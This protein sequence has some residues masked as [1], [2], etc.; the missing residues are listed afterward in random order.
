MGNWKMKRLMVL[1]VVAAFFCGTIGCM[2]AATEGKKKE[3]YTQ[4]LDFK[5]SKTSESK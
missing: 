1:S 2:N 5:E 3:V 4:D